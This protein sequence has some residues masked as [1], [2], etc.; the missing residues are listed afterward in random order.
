M[1]PNSV[2][3]TGNSANIRTLLVDS[4]RGRTNEPQLHSLTGQRHAD[5]EATSTIAE[6]IC[7]MLLRL[8]EQGAL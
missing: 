3:S 4:L 2:S 8:A 1:I 7:Q 5:T 6:A